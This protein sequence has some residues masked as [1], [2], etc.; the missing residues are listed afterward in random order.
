MLCVILLDI[1]VGNIPTAS[2]LGISSTVWNNL[3]D[4]G[5]KLLLPARVTAGPSTR[6]RRT[7]SRPTIR[8]C[9]RSGSGCLRTPP[10]T[11]TPRWT[12]RRRRRAEP[13]YHA[14]IIL[15][16]SRSVG[17]EWDCETSSSIFS[18]ARPSVRNLQCGRR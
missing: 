3:G 6:R 1:G 13:G 12:S 9:C 15:S 14:L 10:T 8:C 18:S 5:S 4:Y 17:R 7:L 16:S 11:T 2:S